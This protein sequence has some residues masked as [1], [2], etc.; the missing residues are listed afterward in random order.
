MALP[1]SENSNKEH[2]WQFQVAKA[3][4]SEVF[5]CVEKEGKQVVVRN[6]KK[7]TILDENAYE[8]YIG[9]KRSIMGTFLRSPH[10]DIDLDIARSKESLRDY[11]L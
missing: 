8:D 3:K 7:F 5:N 6:K 10:P 9:A 4:L 2:C 1:N 11:E